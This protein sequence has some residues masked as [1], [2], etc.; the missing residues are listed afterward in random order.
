VT[1]SQPQPSPPTN[2]HLTLGRAGEDRAAAWYS[3]AGYEVIERNWR[4]RNGEIDLICA[5]RNLLVFCEVKTRRTDR[6]GSP[7]EAVSRPKQIRLRRLAVAYLL[8]HTN[9]GHDVRFDVAAILGSTPTFTVTVIE[10]AF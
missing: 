7:V 5:R 2:R 4:S 1:R 8:L 9:G 6:L 10:D 3:A